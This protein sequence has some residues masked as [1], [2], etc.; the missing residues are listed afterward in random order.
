MFMYQMFDMLSFFKIHVVCESYSFLFFIEYVE[1]IF[2]EGM[3][4]VFPFKFCFLFLC[5]LFGSLNDN[6]EFKILAE[7]VFS[8]K[9]DSSTCIQYILAVS[10]R[11][12]VMRRSKYTK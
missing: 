11:K 7:I 8:F 6:K 9:P 2:L 5:F 1:E 4:K 12:Y 3:R 10:L